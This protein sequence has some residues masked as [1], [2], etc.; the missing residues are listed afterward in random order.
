MFLSC[1]IFG[2]T[3]PRGSKDAEAA[4]LD[5]RSIFKHVKLRYKHL[6]NP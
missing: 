1:R 6:F 3:Q 4:P 5:L 2:R